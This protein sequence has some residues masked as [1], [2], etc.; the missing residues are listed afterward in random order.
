MNFTR[1]RRYVVFKLSDLD[2]DSKV[3]ML[4]MEGSYNRL[5]ALD[6]K[7]PLECVVVEQDWPEYEPTWEAIR[8]RVEQ[9]ET[10]EAPDEWQAQAYAIMGPQEGET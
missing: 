9:S 3:K 10:S 2:T 5:R 6:G 7:P 8:R 4:A 1:E